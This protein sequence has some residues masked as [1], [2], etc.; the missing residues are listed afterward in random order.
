MAADLIDYI[1][2]RTPQTF[3]QLAVE[4]LEAAYAQAHRE[5]STYE[6]PEHR[7]VQGQVRHYRQNAALRRAATHTGLVGVAASTDPRGEYYALVRA[8]GIV[9]G[10]ISVNVTNRYPRAAKHRRA[11]AAIN[12]RLEPITLDLFAPQPAQPEEG[13]GVFLVTINPGRREAQDIPAGIRV[14]VPYSN[15]KGWHLFE[16]VESVM[17]AY[18]P[19]TDIEVPDLALVGLKK[20]LKEREAG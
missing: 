1:A 8:P 13:L 4:E 20:K 10:R 19:A 12:S 9:Y 6:H 11:I 3:L 14:G 16:P 15:F 18:A 7:R 2:A 17:A 5:A